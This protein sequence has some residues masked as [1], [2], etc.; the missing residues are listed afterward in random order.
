[1]LRLRAMI[2][3]ATPCFH[4]AAAVHVYATLRLRFAA[5]FF[6]C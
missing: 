6:A 4:I 1:M 3:D 5:S 2:F